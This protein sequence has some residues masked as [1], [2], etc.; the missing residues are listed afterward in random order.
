MFITCEE[1]GHHI[2]KQ[3]S[4]VTHYW[5]SEFGKVGDNSEMKEKLFKNKHIG[6]GAL[7]HSIDIS[8]EICIRYLILKSKEEF[9][10]LTLRNKSLTNLC[11]QAKNSEIIRILKIISNNS[12]YL[13][14][15]K[16]E[17]TTQVPK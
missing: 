12:I 1:S 17:K 10:D 2:A 3:I 13:S 7:Q 14:M 11:L 16:I 15:E 9:I 6:N 5:F 4:K 8:S